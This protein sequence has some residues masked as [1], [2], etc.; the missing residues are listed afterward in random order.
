MS[1]DTETVLGAGDVTESQLEVWREPTKMGFRF[2]FIFFTLLLCAFPLD[3]APV[4]SVVLPA[5][6]KVWNLIVPWVGNHILGIG[7]TI[8]I[9]AD[10]GDNTWNWVQTFCILVIAVAGGAIW[11]ALDR[12]RPNYATMYKWF[13]LC[14]RYSLAAA[15]FAYGL[16]KV[17]PNQMPFP[18]LAKLVQP[19][20]DQSPMGVIWSFMG[21]SPAYEIF[22]GCVETAGGLLL[23][24][25]RTA[26]VGAMVTAGA[27]LQ[28]WM[29]NM[30]YDIPVKLYSFQLLLASIFLLLPNAWKLAE[31]LVFHRSTRLRGT[32][33]LFKTEKAN[34]IATAAQISLGVVLFVYM[35]AL[36]YHY[37]SRFYGIRGEKPPL[38]GIWN[39]ADLTMD[40]QERPPLLTDT[41]RMRRFIFQYPQSVM[42][43]P[44]DGPSTYYLL[45]L[46]QNRHTMEIKKR[47]NPN[48]KADLTYQQPGPQQLVVDGEMDGHKMHAV[49]QRFDESKFLLISRGFHWMQ[50]SSF[51]R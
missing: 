13:A 19:Y 20:G 5:Y 31:F 30:C 48:W 1:I 44:M 32:P 34:R 18:S 4:L 6:N 42:I 21:T 3:E 40:G 28:V 46:D 33:K 51:N 41:S 12:K 11:T 7:R 23:I 45:S 26:T 24:F 37:S 25:P 29:L 22:A 35:L 14:V 9:S 39:V 15:M 47:N 16:D 17:I 27:M 2:F 43:Q 36:S 10:Q 38:Y 8:I 50:E 49:L